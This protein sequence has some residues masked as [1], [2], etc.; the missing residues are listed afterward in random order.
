[1]RDAL[2]TH[3][4]SLH[5]N[6]GK[7]IIRYDWLATKT[8]SIIVPSCGVDSVPSDVI[9]HLASKTLGRAPL[10]AS[11]T[12]ARMRGGVP[13]GTIATFLSEC[14]DVPPNDFAMALA[15]WSLSPVLGAPKPPSRLVYYLDGGI[16]GSISVMGRVNRALVQRTAGLLERARRETPRG[17]GSGGEAREGDP[18]CYGPS[19]TY[20]EFMQTGGVVS[21]LLISVGLVVTAAAFAFIA[22]VCVLLDIFFLAEW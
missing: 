10:G 7:K 8:Q 12:A 1:M 22:P 9:A 16:V 13:G 17:R 2:Y 4:K 15:D 3:T 21:A 6:C 11:T 19:F 5:T 20:T 18:A 14:E